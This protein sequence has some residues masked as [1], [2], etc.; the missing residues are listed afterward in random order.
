MDSDSAVLKFGADQD[1]TLTHTADTGLT[2]SSTGD[3]DT[4]LIIKSTATDA[5]AAPTLYLTRDSASPAD[6]DLLGNINYAGDNSAGESLT[7][8]QFYATALD[9]SNGSE[10]GDLKFQ[11]VTAGSY[12]IPLTLRGSGIIIPDAGTIGSASDTD[13][14]AIASTGDVV[15]SQ[16]V[17]ITGNLTINGTT[18]TVSSTNTKITDTLILSPFL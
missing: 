10:D 8:T 6:N 1:V 18:T 17:T 4:S 3:N 9:V 15:F 14:I 11:V 2:L 16:A 13:A 7:Y 5:G 12:T